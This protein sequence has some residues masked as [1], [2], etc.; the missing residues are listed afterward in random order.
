MKDNNSFLPI[1]QMNIVKTINQPQTHFFY[2][3][4]DIG[5]KFHEASCIIDKAFSDMQQSWKRSNTI[6][7]NA[8]GEGI[9]H[10]LQFFSSASSNPL[11]FCILLEPTGGYYGFALIEVLKQQG[12]VVHF[13]DNKAVK[14]FRERNLGI[15]EKS[16]KID[17]K[18]LAYMG[19]Q[20]TLT[21]SIYGIRLMNSTAPMQILFKA[22]A[23]ERWSM[24]KQLTR[25]K[26][27][28]QQI[29]SVT[30]PDLKSIFSNGTATRT[31]RKLITKYPT[32]EL[33]SL[34]SEET[35][36][37]DFIS[38]GAK[39][40]AKKRSKELKTLLSHAL[41]IDTSF[42]L[43]RQQLLV[44]DIDRMEG[45]IEKMDAEI[46]KL[47]DNHPYK[48]ILFS[49]PV[50]S[51]TWACTLIGAIGDINR[52]TNYKQFK[53]YMGFVAENRQSGISVQS[54]HLSFQGVRETRR[55]LF[56]MCFTMMGPHND[57][58]PFRT[59]Y[60]RLLQRSMPKMKALGHVCGKLAQVLYGCLKNNKPYDPTIHSLAMGITADRTGNTNV[61]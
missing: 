22:Q 51:Y 54:T 39:S 56:Q 61:H 43:N 16:D 12:Y 30:H 40:I 48:E 23:A 34:Q 49:F 52:F 15:R 45:F 1:V 44:E 18:V 11:D 53:K 2:V 24:Q 59:H 46:K 4:I 19:F 9:S 37:K 14:D 10:L 60:N 5:Y 57:E 42:L 3:G 8:D 41:T 25:R 36:Y 29:L 21:P 47:V 32:I 35:L 55:V 17:C 58:T 26:N 20:K 31:V 7:F 33:M 6:R 13:V 28:L 50:M 38:F 27:Q